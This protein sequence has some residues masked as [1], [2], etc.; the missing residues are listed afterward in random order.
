MLARGLEWSARVALRAQRRNG[1]ANLSGNDLV[2]TG[3]SL[4]Q[5]RV[6]HFFATFEG[7]W[8]S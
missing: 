3:G 7:K 8:F 2:A 1:E 4:L 5:D 6:N